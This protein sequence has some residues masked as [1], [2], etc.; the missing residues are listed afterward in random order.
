[1]YRRDL[2]RLRKPPSPDC[3]SWR[4]LWKFGNH[5]DYQSS[6]KK[7]IYKARRAPKRQLKPESRGSILAFAFL[8]MI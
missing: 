3:P 1:M 7:S 5:F 2:S 8:T 4:G 6:T